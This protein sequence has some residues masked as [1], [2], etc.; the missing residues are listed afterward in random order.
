MNR[1]LTVLLTVAML[2]ASAAPAVAMAAP[3][4]A[5]AT[6]DAVHTDTTTVPDDTDENA[7]DV[8]SPGAKLAGS[9][10]VGQSEMNG[11]IEQRA[12]GHQIAAAA[13]NDSRAQVLKLTQDRT[14]ER[15]TDLEERKASLDEAR[16]NGTI[17]ESQYRAQVSVVAAESARIQSMANTT[18]RTAQD[19]P[20]ET[21]E[22]NGV[23]VTA[24]QQLRD[25]AHD[26]TGPEV[27]EIA[28]Q[29][30]G[31]DVGAPMG[32]PENVP[33]PQAG[34]DDRPGNATE[35][36]PGSGSGDRGGMNETDGQTT[37]NATDTTTVESGDSAPVSGGA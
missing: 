15:L 19:V 11:A 10:G 18:E 21:L 24:L 20:N 5:G 31:N 9:I 17:S 34:M 4:A 1:T 23:N 13:T 12:F 16:E 2:V 32:P 35:E 14:Q 27:A 3:T 36:R 25:R 6:G 29:I 33:G 28:R 37:T 7:S 30:A 8:S 26:V 22:A